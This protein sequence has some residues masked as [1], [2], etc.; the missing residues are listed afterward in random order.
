MARSN[1]LLLFTFLAFACSNPKS[2]EVNVSN[3]PFE[4]A[5]KVISFEL[6][7]GWGHFNLGMKN[8]GN[9]V[10]FYNYSLS[11]LVAFDKASHQMSFLIHI[12]KEGPNGIS[13]QVSDYL[14]DAEDNI[15]LSSS[16]RHLYKV[17]REGKIIE[18]ITFD[19]SSFVEENFDFIS[20]NFQIIDGKYYTAAFPMVFQYNSLSIDELSAIPNLVSYDLENHEIE[21]LSFYDKTYLGSNL[22]KF[23]MPFI[24]KGKNN[25]III[26]HNYK[27]IYVYKNNE[28]NKLAA[29][30][31]KFSPE[32]PVSDRD[33]FE[34]MDEIM[35]LIN[36]TDSYESIHFLPQQN[37]Y[38]RV[39]KFEDEVEGGDAMRQYVPSR[40]AFIFLDEQFAKTGELILPENEANGN[41]VFD[42]EE[43]IWFSV[44][45]PDNPGLDEEK[46][47]F[48]LLKA[49]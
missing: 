9:H 23:I 24:N 41:Y 13:G 16:N 37:T 39:A 28:V 18:D 36:Y 45:H 20:Y 34:D 40:W 12:D 29:S 38:V 47:Q 48:R 17:D 42:S 44:D 21:K 26:N 8:Q 5:E 2:D 3:E 46:L 27:D 30:F 6:P 7:E 35:R 4:L 32:P 19:S 1:Y 22:N 43:G 11:S 33:I 10:Y 14:I 49:K 25:E 31:S 15:W